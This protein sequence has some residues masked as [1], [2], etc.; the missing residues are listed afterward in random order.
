M[1]SILTSNVFTTVGETVATP[2]GEVYQR[3]RYETTSSGELNTAWTSR[4]RRSRVFAHPRGR[5]R[6]GV[7]SSLERAIADDASGRLQIPSGRSKNTTRD[8]DA[9]SRW[10][11]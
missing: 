5:C 11:P 1:A 8:L 3:T 10:F 6:E 2:T 4:G 9:V 7:Q